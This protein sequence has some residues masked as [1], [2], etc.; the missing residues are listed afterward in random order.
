MFAGSRTGGDACSRNAADGSLPSM[1]LTLFTRAV[2]ES[3]VAEIRPARRLLARPDFV[4]TLLLATLCASTAVPLL[5]QTAP[6]TA[7]TTQLSLPQTPL[8]PASFARWH[9]TPAPAS[10]AATMPQ[11]KLLA[12]PTMDR[13]AKEDGVRR[14][15]SAI[16]SASGQASRLSVEALQFADATG[17]VASYTYLRHL[18]LEER[19]AD[20]ARHGNTNIASHGAKTVLREG[21]SL[22]V[23]E[24][25]GETLSPGDVRALA[26]TLPKM[27]GPQG[28]PPL[29]PTYLPTQGMVPRSV[30]YAVGP[31]GYEAE[32]GKLPTGLLGFDKAGEVATAAYSGSSSGTGR[33][34]LL[35]LPT[36]EIAGARGRALEA[37]LNSPAASD[38]NLGTVRLRRVGPLLALASNGFTPD[39]SKM[40]LDS[41]HLR[42]EVTW[43]KPV[44][45]EFHAE[46]RKTASLLTSIMVFSGVG[47]LAA[48]L[49]GLFLGFGRAW[50]RVLLG[51]PAATEAE[52]LRLDLRSKP[53]GPDLTNS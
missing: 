6:A 21:S 41:I 49:L 27:S 35:L 12:D 28:L 5:S 11:L 32:G 10:D 29:L 45:P 26:D 18:E 38:A 36:P 42:T 22:V 17:A 9:H 2:S 34:T 13:I 3:P 33:L 39:Q 46:I 23:I 47:A 25:S 8:L 37:W 40:L 52:F 16:Y 43:N 53:T 7:L 24:A 15:A 4:T 50:I 30:E 44:P 31:A 1:R 48:I 14:T 51:K 19:P 20:P